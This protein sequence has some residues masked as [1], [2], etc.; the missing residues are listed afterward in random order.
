MFAKLHKYRTYRKLVGFLAARRR[1]R[2]AAAAK[3]SGCYIRNQKPVIPSF[4][5]Q[6]FYTST[7]NSRNILKSFS[8]ER[9][10]TVILMHLSSNH[11]NRKIP[12]YFGESL[13]SITHL[14]LSSHR[15]KFS[16]ARGC[17]LAGSRGRCASAVCSFTT[18][19]LFASS[20]SYNRQVVTKELDSCFPSIHAQTNRTTNRSISR[21][22]S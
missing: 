21:A 9:L 17:I 11:K 15:F 12:F 4:W 10:T 1:I 18:V 19:R 14:S 8:T 6:Y 22:I 5:Q 2:S 20:E 7:V 16:N 13:F 3:S